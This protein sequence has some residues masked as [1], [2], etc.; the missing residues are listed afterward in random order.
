[1][2]KIAIDIRALLAWALVEEMPKQAR[3]LRAGDGDFVSAPSAWASIERL[4]ILGVRVDTSG[5]AP[6]DRLPEPAHPDA[7]VVDEAV[8]ALA[9]AELTMPEGFDALGDCIGLTE[10]ERA[11][12]HQAG[13]DIACAR[14]SRL[15]ALVVRRVW[16]GG[17]PTWRDHGPI[18]RRP[19]IGPNGKA[20]WFRMI[21]EA[22]GPGMPARPREVDGRNPKTRKP[23][24]G[25][26]HRF[27]LH[28]HPLVLVGERIEYQ[29][30]ALALR[31]VADQV[32]HRL[33]DWRLL[34]TM[35]PLWP[36]M[37]EEEQGAPRILISGLSTKARQK[38]DTAA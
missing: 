12:A 6:I 26:Y 18:Q 4:A 2:A 21:N 32:R 17:E 24:P 36:W 30:W 7:L 20:R 29:A 11:E 38:A 31:M 1:M 22:A 16:A 13:W 5:A 35:P 33:T 27:T 19:M 25:A 3:F 9:S 23:Y 34:D 14:G 8:R 10:A 37:G 15:M 28:P